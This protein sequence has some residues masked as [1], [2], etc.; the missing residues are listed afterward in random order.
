PPPPP[1]DLPSFPTRRSSDLGSLDWEAGAT[2]GT[3]E[4]DSSGLRW[5]TDRRPGSLRR[6]AKSAGPPWPWGR[7]PCR[8]RGDGSF[9]P[10][11]ETADLGPSARPFRIAGLPR[12]PVQDR[13]R[14]NLRRDTPRHPAGAREAVH[15]RHCWLS[16]PTF[17]R[18]ASADGSASDGSPSSV[19]PQQESPKAAGPSTSR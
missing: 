3:T 12:R 11:D 16:V 8:S 2:H 7:R 5:S 10:R 9:G 17:L 14:A 6:P 1:R 15:F 18:A 13:S 19:V 4:P